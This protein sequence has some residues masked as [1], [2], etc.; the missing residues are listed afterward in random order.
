MTDKARPRRLLLADDDEAFTKGCARVLGRYFV[1]ECVHSVAAALDVIRSGLPID[2]VWSDNRMPGPG[3][4]VKV[5]VAAAEHHPAATLLVVTGD[6]NGADLT[7]LPDRAHVFSKQRS[8][9]A[10]SFLIRAVANKAE[11]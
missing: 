3:D 2:V 7:G 1:V 10:V 5:L 6:P 8:T 4:G 11:T 9:S